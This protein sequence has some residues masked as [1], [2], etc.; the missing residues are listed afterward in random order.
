[1]S[2]PAATPHTPTPSV[3][4]IPAARWLAASMLFVGGIL[5]FA[6][7]FLPLGRASYSATDVDPATTLISIPAQEL[8]RVIQ[9]NL[10]APASASFVG[11][12]FWAFWL[13]GAPLILAILGAVALLVR[14]WSPGTR[15]RVVSMFLVVLG[16][17]LTLVSCWGYLNPIFGYQGAIRTLAYEPVVAAVGY[18]SALAGATWLTATA[19]R[20]LR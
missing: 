16:L 9:N 20:S 6:A 13:W 19:T 18:L 2:T 5:V 15:T 10:S 17:G 1:M 14:R 8:I 7:S 4:A 11:T 12:G 3:P